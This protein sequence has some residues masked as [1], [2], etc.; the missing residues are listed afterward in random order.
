MLENFPDVESTA[1]VSSAGEDVDYDKQFDDN[2]LLIAY[3]S[4]QRPC[5]NHVW[6]SSED[7]NKTEEKE[8]SSSQDTD[9]SVVTRR[10]K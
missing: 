6:E 4:K 7:E 1:E 5:V 10:R 2:L 8:V 9:S 3:K